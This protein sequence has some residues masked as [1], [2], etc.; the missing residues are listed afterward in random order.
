MSSPHGIDPRAQNDPRNR[1]PT[2]DEFYGSDRPDHAVLPEDRPRGGG[3]TREVKHRGTWA[4]VALVAGIIL[5]ILLGIA[6]FP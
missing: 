1:Y 5:L 4:T 6:L 2:D 3:G